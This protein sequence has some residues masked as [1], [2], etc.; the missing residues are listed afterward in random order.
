MWRLKACS[1]SIYSHCTPERCLRSPNSN[2][3]HM[4]VN[5]F[6]N[7]LVLTKQLR[8]MLWIIKLIYLLSEPSDHF[9]VGKDSRQQ[10]SWTDD[11]FAKDGAWRAGEEAGQEDEGGLQDRALLPEDKVWK[12]LQDARRKLQV[13]KTM[14]TY[15]DVNCQG[16]Q[17][18]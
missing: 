9:R 12:T 8:P 6:W 3:T 4:T 11:L 10:D 13:R 16:Y 14:N 7:Q 2:T 1:K 15:H 5:H 17:K 18:Q